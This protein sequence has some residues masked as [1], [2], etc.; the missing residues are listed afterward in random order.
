MNSPRKPSLNAGPFGSW[1]T[2]TIEAIEGR[3]LADVPCGDCTACCQSSQF[4]HVNRDETRTLS[5][6]PKELLFP[7]PGG[8][9]GNM[10]MG[11]DDSGRCPMLIQSK[12]SIYANRPTTCK[13]Y[14]C[15]IFPAAGISAKDNEKPQIA[16]QAQRW[17][18]E[19]PTEDDRLKHLAVKT[20]A[21]FLREHPGL[22]SRGG[23]ANATQVAICAIRI[24]QVFIDYGLVGNNKTRITD[25]RDVLDAIEKMIG[26]A[27]P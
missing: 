10:V 26:K 7:V 20:A 14:D 23:A 2:S 3:Q 22:F 16:E 11:Y 5:L 19:Y 1:L 25:Q 8:S 4:I 27:P 18:F 13:S 17:T 24:H 12:C 15:R 6:I 21:R 9:Q